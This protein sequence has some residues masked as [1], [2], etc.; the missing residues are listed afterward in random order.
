M[1]EKVHKF[2]A[3]EICGEEYG[4][5]KE[6]I[7]CE[8]KPISEDKGVKVGDIVRITGGD[9]KGKEAKVTRVY[10]IDKDWGHYSW[11]RYWHTVAL[12]ADIINHWGS[13]M[14]TFD[15]YELLTPNA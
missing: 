6:A 2:Y 10:I 8:S 13:R 1:K 11:K 9:G 4:T 5:E 15:Q 14:L 3:C 12:N 7:E